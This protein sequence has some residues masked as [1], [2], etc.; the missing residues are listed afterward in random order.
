[1][2]RQLLLNHFVDILPKYRQ[3][4]SG[5]LDEHLVDQRLFGVLLGLEFLISFGHYSEVQSII[6]IFNIS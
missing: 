2:Y 3:V 4:H 1:M 6:K 5:F